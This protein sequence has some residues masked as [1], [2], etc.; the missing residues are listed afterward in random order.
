MHNPNPPGEPVEKLLAEDGYLFR[1][2]TCPSY[3]ARI[4]DLASDTGGR[5]RT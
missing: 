1:N 5:K 2:A 3:L 4:L